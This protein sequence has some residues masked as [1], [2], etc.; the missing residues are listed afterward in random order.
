MAA[1]SVDAIRALARRSGFEWSD[2][3][4]AAMLPIAEASVAY[5]KIVESTR[6]Q[7]VLSTSG[8]AS[9]RTPITAIA[10]QPSARRA[11]IIP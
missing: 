9:A 4:I 10:D 7:Y 6:S 11:V 2:E 5:M 8:P 3:D 1:L